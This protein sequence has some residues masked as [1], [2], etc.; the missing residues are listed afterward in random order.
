MTNLFK[1]LNINGTIYDIACI[2]GKIDKIGKSEGKG[3]DFCGK[4]AFAGLVDI[5]THGIGG[6]DT[7][8]ADFSEMAKLYAEN[9]TT[10]VFPTTMTVAHDDIV[11]VL[12]TKIPTYGAKIA[13]I[14]LEGPYIN[15]KYK[16]A[17]NAKFIKLPDIN[18]FEKYKNAK[19]ITIAPELS[20]SI[21]FIKNTNMLICVGHTDADYEKVVEAAQA[22][23]KCVTHIFNAMPSP[24][25]RIPSV[26]GA[27]YDT[28]M[29]VQVICDGVHIHPSMIRI[30]YKLFGADRMILIS[31][32]VRAT[33]LPDGK[34]EFGGQ[35]MTVISGK[36]VMLDGAIA[37]STSTLFD[38][39]KCAI[40]FGIPESDA[41][42]MA[43]ETPA[44]MLGLNCGRIQKGYSCDLIVLDDNNNID[45]VIIGGK[46]LKG[47]VEQ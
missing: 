8:D 28:D 16:G 2:D 18:E 10:T 36:A 32:S 46:I 19:I 26:V 23:A 22:G 21:E 39:V 27:A 13:G 24:H 4:R 41:F 33:G 45:T 31:D 12:N 17:Q 37:G 5:H 38:C 7:M 11:K 29:Y 14:H 20:G 3:V 42:K 9:G 25:H 30:L 34:Y 1:N 44:K 40:K 47:E 15:E 35:E 6:I 43:S